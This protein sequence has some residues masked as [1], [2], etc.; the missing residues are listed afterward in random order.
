MTATAQWF[1]PVHQH[2]LVAQHRLRQ[3]ATQIDLAL[4]H[5][6][7]QANGGC[8]FGPIEVGLEANQ[9]TSCSVITPV[10]RLSRKISPTVMRGF[11]T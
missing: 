9:L 1:D 3:A 6:A 7:P 10:E 4:I 2:F 11:V 8:L 5:Q